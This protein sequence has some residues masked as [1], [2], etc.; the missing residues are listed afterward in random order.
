MAT[1]VVS[2]EGLGLPL[3][4]HSQFLLIPTDP[5]QDMAEPIREAGSTS[6]KAYFRKGKYC[7]DLKNEGK[8]VRKHPKNT[9]VNEGEPGIPGAVGD[10]LLQPVS[11]GRNHDGFGISLE[12]MERITPEQIF[13]L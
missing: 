11:F 13:T 2:V 8:S 7:A 5:Q 6:V 1:V 12:L 9:K 10:I 4:G 3:S